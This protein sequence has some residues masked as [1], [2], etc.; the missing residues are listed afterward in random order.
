MPVVVAVSKPV[1]RDD[2][3]IRVGRERKQRKRPDGVG[4]TAADCDGLV[5]LNLGARDRRAG[6]GDRTVPVTVPVVP[7]TAG[8]ANESA[9]VRNVDAARKRRA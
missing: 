7:A 3:R 6:V 9:N 4:G 8:A 2:E 5:A 1:L